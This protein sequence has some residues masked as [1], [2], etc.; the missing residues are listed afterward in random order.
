MSKPIRR[1]FVLLV[2]IVA[3]I[4]AG[5]QEEELPST[6][7]TRLI[8][9][10]NI[11]LKKDLASREKEIERLNTLHARQIKRQQEELAKCVQ[12]KEALEARLQQNIKKQVSGVL[13][14]VL[15]ENAKMREEITALK[16]QIEK[17]RGQVKGEAGPS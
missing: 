5:C 10:E 2:S 6:K 7:K 15:D 8:V 1:V 12:Q 14:S 3:V 11:R 13:T 16:A 4:I 17:L 9:A